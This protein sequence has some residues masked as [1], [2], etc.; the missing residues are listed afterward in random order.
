VVGKKSPSLSGPIEG[1]F[2]PTT[3]SLRGEEKPTRMQGG[4]MQGLRRKKIK[5]ICRIKNKNNLIG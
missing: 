1:L 4:H 5:K 3:A 2:F